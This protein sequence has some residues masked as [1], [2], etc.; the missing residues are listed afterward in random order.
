MK[1]LP[2]RYI[3]L[4][5]SSVH[6]SDMK[7]REDH[8]NKNLECHKRNNDEKHPGEVCF[9][10]PQSAQIDA[11]TCLEIEM[12][13]SQ[14]DPDTFGNLKGNKK[15]PIEAIEGDE[16]DKIEEMYLE[17]IPTAAQKLSIKQYATMIKE[18]FRHKKVFLSEDQH[19]KVN[20]VKI[21]SITLNL[22]YFRWQMLLMS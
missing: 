16:G 10:E 18:F 7:N 19:L 20:T 9:H 1:V 4:P 17:H 11:R 8:K 13:F 15:T 22:F 6:L 2:T 21:C 5:P 12:D 3:T 14:T